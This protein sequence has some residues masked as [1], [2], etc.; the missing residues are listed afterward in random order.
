MFGVGDTDEGDSVR[1]DRAADRGAQNDVLET[2][3]NRHI[4]I[5]GKMDCSGF[6]NL[7]DSHRHVIRINSGG[8]GSIEAKQAGIER[9]VTCARSRKRTIEHNRNGTIERALLGRYWGDYASDF[10]LG[11]GF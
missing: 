10:V 8:I 2:A 1:V 4:F 3:G 5:A 9:A 6:A 7:L 11:D